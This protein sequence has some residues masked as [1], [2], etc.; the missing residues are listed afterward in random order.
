ML[1]P[2]HKAYLLSRTY[3]ED[4]LLTEEVFSLSTFYGEDRL[5]VHVKEPVIAWAARHPTG[6]LIG[7]QTR[8][9]GDKK[10]L[11]YQNPSSRHMPTAYGT[12]A[13]YELLY[14]KGR[15][16]FT[17]GAIDRAAVKQALPNEA[18]IARL[19]RGLSQQLLQLMTRH[20]TQVWMV[21]D[22]DGPGKT[23]ADATERILDGLGIYN[24]TITLPA[25]DPAKFYETKGLAA[26]KS[27]ID[28][29]T[30]MDPQWQEI[31]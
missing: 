13:D 8:T 5:E 19:T 28:R 20:A 23:A 3:T 17:E 27:A 25:K 1:L 2:E 18:V 9:I 24:R 7:L 26:L 12:R 15:V 11:W 30:M 10:Y 31:P 14:R 29:Q 6:K 21:F 4:L 16:F 22:S